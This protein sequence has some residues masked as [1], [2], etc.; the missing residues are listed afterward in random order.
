MR[1][2]AGMS[3]RI[4]CR[5]HRAHA[6]DEGERLRGYRDRIPAHGRN[7]KVDLRRRRRAPE[8]GV[9][10]LE[11]APVHHRRTDAIEPGP[12]VGGPRRGEGGSRD[13]LRIQ[14]VGASLRR[15][16]PHGKRARQRL[17]LEP[18]AETGHVAGLETRSGGG[19]A[20]GCWALDVHGLSS[21]ARSFGD[22]GA[23][24][25]S[26]PSDESIKR[27][28]ETFGQGC[29]GSRQRFGPPDAALGETSRH[30]RHTKILISAVRRAADRRY[31]ARWCRSLT[32]DATR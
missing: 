14:S 32:G 25:R 26:S 4:A 9:G 5:G 6:L 24:M 7:G 22:G 12:L 23:T 3:A 2:H 17:R 27:E 11:R 10:G 15:V 18:V 8:T 30:G 31:G 19:D 1:A 29:C 21:R 20:E 28:C 13:L 16:A